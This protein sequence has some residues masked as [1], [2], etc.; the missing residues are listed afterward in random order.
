MVFGRGDGKVLNVAIS[1][2]AAVPWLVRA[3]SGLLPR[4]LF[5]LE[6]ALRFSDALWAEPSPEERPW[7]VH[8]E[9]EPNP[10]QGPLR[11]FPQAPKALSFKVWARSEPG[12][13]NYMLARSQQTAGAA[14]VVFG[15]R[16]SMKESEQTTCRAVPC[17]R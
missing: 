8:V 14:G 6:G 1:S 12:S 17:Q 7:H 3:A 13:G 5:A 10:D 2:P 4:G 11:L 15:G 16:R 9:E